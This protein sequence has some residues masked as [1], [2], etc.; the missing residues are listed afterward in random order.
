MTYAEQL[1][2]EEDE[3]LLWIERY[4][5][6]MLAGMEL[7]R[8]MDDRRMG[9]LIYFGDTKHIETLKGELNLVRINMSNEE[10][11]FDDSWIYD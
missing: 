9:A 7:A 5:E 2:Q 4:T 10:T 11:W 1:I 8:D 3:L 6:N